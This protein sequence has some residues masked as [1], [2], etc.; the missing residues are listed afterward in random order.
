[1]LWNVVFDILMQYYNEKLS[2]LVHQLPVQ[3]SGSHSDFFF[4]LIQ[5]IQ[6]D[7]TLWQIWYS[8]LK[9]RLETWQKPFI[10]S[11]ST[12]E[13]YLLSLEILD[14]WI[15]DL[16]P[17]PLLLLVVGSS[18]NSAELIKMAN[19]WGITGDSQPLG[20]M[21]EPQAS[22]GASIFQPHIAHNKHHRWGGLTGILWQNVPNAEGR[23][24]PLLRLIVI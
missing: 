23:K 21:F 17:C 9:E 4:F 10:I 7:I 1:M 19:I 8:A 5:A 11:T 12:V 14:L 24:Q 22:R 13:A 20:H 18:A 2:G 16:W 6:I 15:T 3:I